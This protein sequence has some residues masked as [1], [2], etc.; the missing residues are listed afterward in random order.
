MVDALTELSQQL[1]ACLLG[2]GLKVTCAES[3]T[4]GGGAEVITRTPGSSDWFDVG[5]VTYADRAKRDVLGV[6]T[7]S[8]S[9]WGA[10]SERVVIEMAEGALSASRADLA[11]AISGIAGPEG[12]TVEKPVGTVWF[13]WARRGA[14]TGTRHAKFDGNRDEVR[15]RA[16]EMALRGLIAKAAEN[17]TL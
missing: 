4:G 8:L 11:V 9:R 16:I 3:C 1:G 5:F 2:R 14:A 10:V 15:Q 6:S 12:G 17:T 13:A 7:T